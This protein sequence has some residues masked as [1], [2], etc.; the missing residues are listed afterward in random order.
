[1]EGGA[2]EAELRLDPVDP[3]VQ[4]GMGGQVEAALARDPRV[5]HQG[6]VGERQPLADE[7]APGGRGLV[8]PCARAALPRSTSRGSRSAG[9]RP[10]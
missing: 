2:L 6:D 4:P 7:E 3:V 10:R 5:G 9:E 8:E 1:M